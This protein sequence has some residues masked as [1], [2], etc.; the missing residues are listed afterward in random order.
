MGGFIFLKGTVLIST[1][2]KLRLSLVPVLWSMSNGKNHLLCINTE[3]IA[4]NVGPPVNSKLLLSRTI[5]TEENIL[6][7]NENT[8]GIIALRG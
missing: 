5:G 8:S 7:L 6:C 2:A 3:M 1:Q 4:N